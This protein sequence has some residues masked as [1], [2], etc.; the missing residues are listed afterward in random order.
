METADGPPPRGRVVE[1]EYEVCAT[2][3]SLSFIRIDF[4][5]SIEDYELGRPAII[6]VVL[7]RDVSPLIPPLS[8][9]EVYGW[10]RES[11]KDAEIIVLDE[12]EEAVKVYNEC[13]RARRFISIPPLLSP[14]G[15][16]SGGGEMASNI[17]RYH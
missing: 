13:K 8:R 1:M 7:R 16:R 10:L 11:Y 3:V 9:S 5:K 15:G 17:H 12:N 2:V 6:Y 4:Y 14:R